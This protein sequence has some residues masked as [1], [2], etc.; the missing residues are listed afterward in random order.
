[1]NMT[2]CKECGKEIADSASSCPHCGAARNVPRAS[3]TTWELYKEFW[4]KWIVFEGRVRRRDYL[5]VNLINWGVMLA[6][7]CIGVLA[8][9]PSFTLFTSFY[10]I[11][12]I[13]PTLSMSVRRLHDI[14]RSGLWYLAML[15]PVLGIIPCIALLCFAG[16]S[17]WNRYGPDPKVPEYLQRLGG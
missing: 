5:L 4:A 9:E 10:M 12:I 17:G 15:I 3:L 8:N 13:I 1:M 16:Q 2:L 7:M 6:A 14:G 11:I